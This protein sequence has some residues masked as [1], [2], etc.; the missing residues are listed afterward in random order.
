MKRF[1]ST[2]ELVA[3]LN[4][5]AKDEWEKARAI[6]AW[7]CFNIVYDVPALFSSNFPPQDAETVFK[8]RIGVCAGYSMLFTYLAEK[9]NMMLGPTLLK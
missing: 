3:A 8:G 4:E 7:I 5:V 2:D 6:C 1:T 9:M